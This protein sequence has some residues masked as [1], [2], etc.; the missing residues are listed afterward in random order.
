MKTVTCEVLPAQHDPDV[1]YVLTP[2]DFTTEAYAE[3]TN[4]NI[5]WITP[6]EQSLFHTARVHV[7]GVGGIGGITADSLLRLGVGEIGISDNDTF[8]R[9]NINRQ[10]GANRNTV[11]HSK[12]LTTARM[13]REIANDT[14]MRVYPQGVTEETVDDLVLHADLICDE[15]EFFA[16]GSRILLHQ[17]M[18]EHGRTILNCPTVGHRAYVTKYTPDSMHIEEVLEMD[19]RTA[20]ALQQKIQGGTATSSDITRVMDAML[21]FA[22]PEVPEYSL[23]LNAYSTVHALHDRLQ[24]GIAS[25][26]ATNPKMASGFLANQVVFHVLQASPLQRNFQLPPAMPGYVMIDAGLLMAKSFDGKWW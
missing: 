21:R 22:A 7:A 2:I 14:R 16:V 11:G 17:K 3:R 13:L 4:R 5:G 15:I 19:Y 9:S 8:D 12:A 26:I 18:R 20:K 10:F 24:Q 6:E 1:A 25:I 23:D